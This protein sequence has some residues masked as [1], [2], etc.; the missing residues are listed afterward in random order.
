M[1]IGG[2]LDIT[3]NSKLSGFARYQRLHEERSSPDDQQGRDP[4]EFSLSN[5]LVSYFHRFDRVSA[6]LDGSTDIYDYDDVQ[7]STGTTNE[8]DRDRTVLTG[9]ARVGY[10]I[11]PDYEAFL[12]GST[13]PAFITTMSMISA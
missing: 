1:G 9:T 12:R 10:E 7:T 13:I 5:F 11:V 3:R 6:H 8:D 4:T 2:R